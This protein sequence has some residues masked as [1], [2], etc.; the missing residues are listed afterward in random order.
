MDIYVYVYVLCSVDPTH[1][2]TYPHPHPHAL[3]LSH[4]ITHT[5]SCQVC[6]GK[7]VLEAGSGTGLLAHMLEQAGAAKVI[8]ECFVSRVCLCLCVVFN[9]KYCHRLHVSIEC[10]AQTHTQ[11]TQLKQ[12]NT[13]Q[14]NQPPPP[15]QTRCWAASRSPRWRPPARKS[16]PPRP[17]F[18]PRTC[19]CSICRCRPR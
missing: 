1:P 15:N 12:T 4:I 6:K 17:K 5:P 13:Q 2:L 3:S 19:G 16:Y 18:S 14:T 7:R 11:T 9:L 8:G 10:H